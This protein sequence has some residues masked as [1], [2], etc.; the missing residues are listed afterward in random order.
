MIN[1]RSVKLSGD[2]LVNFLKSL[3]ANDIQSIEVITTPPAKYEA[4]GNSGLINIVMKKTAIDT[5]SG[6]AFGNYLQTKYAQGTLG[7]SFNYRKK[8]FSFYANTSYRNGKSYTEDESAIFYP[9]LKWE[10]EGNYTYNSN[11]FNAR[12]GFDIR[13][14]D[15]WTVGAQYIGSLGKTKSN[16]NNRVDLFDIVDNSNAG[17]IAT[18]SDGKSDY[19]MHSGNFHSI[20]QLDTVGR[21]ISNYAVQIDIEHPIKNISLNYGAKLSFTHTDNR[22]QVYNLSS[23]IPEND[24]CQTN[25]FLYKENVQALYGS[26]SMELGKWSLEA[27]LRA[28]NTQFTGNP[29][30]RPVFTDNLTLGYVYNNQF[31]LTPKSSEGYVAYFQTNN[32]FYFNKEQ[33]LSAGFDFTFAPESNSI[34]LTYNY[35]QKNL[36]AFIKLL[37]FDK[38]FSVTLTGNNLLQDYSFN[39]RSESNGILQY[40]KGYYNPLFLRLAVSYNFGSKKVNVQQRKVSNEEEKGRVY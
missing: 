13:V 23:G 27:G 21:K 30:L 20:V 36:N 24:P 16:S 8:T 25:K 26:G 5:W 9:K 15:N 22:I 34:T 3:R 35:S 4:E 11:S 7:G 37:L 38:T 2:E 33:T 10:N 32:F 6:S 39:S 19:D 28:E 40:A 31:Q 29:E 18:N 1:D 14:K 17:L 12:T